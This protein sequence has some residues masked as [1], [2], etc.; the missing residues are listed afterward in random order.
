[1]DEKLRQRYENLKS[2]FDNE[3]RKEAFQNLV[4][5]V[6]TKTEYLTA[7][8]STKYHL[9]REC[10][11]LEHS[12][13]VTE[14][15]LRLRKTL[16]PEIPVSSC[17]IVGLFH[18]LGKVGMPG[19]PY[20]VPGIP[21]ARQKK[22]GYSATNKYSINPKLLHMSHAHRSIYLILPNMMLTENE[23]QA[24]LCHDGMYIDDNKSYAHKEGDLAV[25]LHYADFWSCRKEPVDEEA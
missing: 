9:N 10:G 13:N 6:E 4:K 21:T 17:I 2:L 5:F 20:Y 23:T 24:I 14:Y 22:Y 1:M 15:L 12:V 19:N 11:L 25:L 7:P 8:A 3:S 16:A 18:D